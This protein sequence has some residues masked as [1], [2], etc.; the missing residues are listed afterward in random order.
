[1]SDDTQD[2]ATP[3][4]G[5]DERKILFE[6]A[7]TLGIKHS[8]NIGIE[9]LRQKIAEVLQDSEPVAPLEDPSEE[10]EEDAPKA[11][12]RKVQT[13]DERFNS[14]RQKIVAEAMKLVRIRLTCMDPSKKDLNGEIFTIANRYLGTV[15]KFVPYTEAGGDGWHVPHCIYTHL[16]SMRFQAVRVVKAANGRERIITSD[17]PAF[18]IEV[19]PQLTAA[20]LKKLALQQ[21][22][23]A[24][25]VEE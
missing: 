23:A 6:R 5:T 25:Q 14:T 15:R 18:S 9:T 13:K 3:M 19:L 20:E 21:A 2:L 10:F 24:G 8:P 22:A 16:K 7:K 4:P 17:A 12:R 11:P 1:M